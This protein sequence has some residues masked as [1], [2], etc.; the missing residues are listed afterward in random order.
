MAYEYS[1]SS[2]IKEGFLSP[3]NAQTIPLK[4]DLTEVGTQAGDFK[5]E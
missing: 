2:A 1:L 5:N 3:I 4:L